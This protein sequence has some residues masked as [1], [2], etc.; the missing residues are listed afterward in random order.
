MTPCGD[1]RVVAQSSIEK[2]NSKLGPRSDKKYGTKAWC[3]KMFNVS[4]DS[5]PQCL[6]RVLG[7]KRFIF[8][9]FVPHLATEIE[10]SLLLQTS[11]FGIFTK[12]DHHQGKDKN[13]K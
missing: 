9:Q 11:L 12:F 10:F 4:I 13:H 3:G 5:L 7:V 6:H 1:G 2:L 8:P